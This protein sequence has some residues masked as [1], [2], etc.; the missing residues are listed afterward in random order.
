M[1]ASHQKTPVL[2]VCLPPPAGADWKDAAGERGGA[3]HGSR[4]P[5]PP[6]GHGRS[7]LHFRPRTCITASAHRLLLVSFQEDALFE[8][9]MKTEVS[10][11]LKMHFNTEPKPSD[12][13]AGVSVIMVSTENVPR[14]NPVICKRHCGLMFVDFPLIFEVCDWFNHKYEADFQIFTA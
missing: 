4:R 13:T 12:T 1:S 11:K 2:I 14:G 9:N 8:N 3:T 5:L 6:L 7:R 10:G